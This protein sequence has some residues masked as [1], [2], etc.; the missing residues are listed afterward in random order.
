MPNKWGEITADDWNQATGT[1]TGITGALN[2]A[3]AARQKR[4]TEQNFTAIQNNPESPKYTGGALSQAQARDLYAKDLQNQHAINLSGDALKVRQMQD[5]MSG[6]L[7]E[8]PRKSFIQIPDEMYAGVLG[9]QA[10]ANLADT[11]AQSEQGKNAIMQ[12]RLARG[13]VQYKQFDAMRNMA[14]EALAKGD[15]SSAVNAISELSQSLPIPYELQNYKPEIQ[16]FDVAYLDSDTGHFQPSSQLKL[17]DV[18]EMLNKTGEKEFVK[19]IAINAEAVRQGNIEK[20]QKPL[21]AKN[22]SGKD[23]LVIPQKKTFAPT[24]VDIEVRDAT[25]NRKIMFDSWEAF[26]DAGFQLEDLKHTKDVSATQKATSDAAKAKLDLQEGHK[27][28][29]RD[30]VKFQNDQQKHTK[31]K[32]EGIIKTAVNY[33]TNP[34]EDAKTNLTALLS[35]NASSLPKNAAYTRALEFYEENKDSA[36]SLTGVEAEKFKIAKSFMDATQAYFSSSSDDGGEKSQAEAYTNPKQPT[37][38]PD[39]K[40]AKDGKW[41]IQDENGGWAYLTNEDIRQ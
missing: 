7:Q 20:R 30:D 31:T 26:Q 14:T 32:L 27:K 2:T 15:V 34:Q 37:N 6:W 24:Q 18:I 8:N 28:V 11:I 33:F 12:N 29:K 38:F 17:P 10:Y 16:T 41:Y 21:Y 1:I 40:R 39:A 5:E 36:D 23:Y 22:A 25:T 3:N 13:A 19:Q 4:E 35:G 9:Q